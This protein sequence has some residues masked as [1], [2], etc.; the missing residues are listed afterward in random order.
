[1]SEVNNLMMAGKFFLVIAGELVLIFVV[2][3]CAI[4]LWNE[5]RWRGV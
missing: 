5:V 1:M 3:H 2:G 4:D